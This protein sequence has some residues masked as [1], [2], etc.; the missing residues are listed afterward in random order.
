LLNKENNLSHL[1]KAFL[2]SRSLLHSSVPIIKKG[3]DRMIGALSAAYITPNPGNNPAAALKISVPVRPLLLPNMVFE[4]VV[5]VPARS[6]ENTTPAYQVQLLEDLIEQLIGRNGDDTSPA[7]RTESGD[8][9][10]TRIAEAGARLQAADR[11]LK[12]FSSGLFPAAGTFVN[13]LA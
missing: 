4:H 2:S 8:N 12:G 6:G 7:P 13:R 9:L 10:A 3:D 5:A 1:P 11:S